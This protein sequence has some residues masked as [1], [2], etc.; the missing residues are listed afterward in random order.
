MMEEI[1]PAATT[2][3]NIIKDNSNINNVITRGILIRNP[4][5]FNDPKLPKDYMLQSISVS[6]HGAHPPFKTIFSKDKA[7]IF[8]TND[9]MEINAANVNITFTYFEYN[10]QEYYPKT[11]ITV[12]IDLN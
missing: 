1:P 12:H 7:K 10:G 6:Q 5:P 2:E 9:D 11:S 4:E 3:F 8:I